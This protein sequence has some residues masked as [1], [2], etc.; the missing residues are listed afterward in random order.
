MKYKE[1]TDI[2]IQWCWD[3]DFVVQTGYGDI[4][5]ISFPDGE[6]A[7]DYPYAFLNPT[8]VSMN[9]SSFTANYNLIV[10]EQVTDGEQREIDGQSLCI[11]IIQDLISQWRKR[12]TDYEGF[13]GNLLDIELPVSIEVFK[14]RF[15]DDVVGA[16]AAIVINYGKAIDGCDTPIT[17]G[18]P[19]P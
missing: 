17:P 15:Q 3:H 7:P 12:L 16:T 14:E 4:S 1:I 6:D 8:G 13:D 5:D 18:T 11:S 2:I 10:M 19:R 9:D